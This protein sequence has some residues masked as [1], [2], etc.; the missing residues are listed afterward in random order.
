[1][2]TYQQLRTNLQVLLGEAQF[3]V[4]LHPQNQEYLHHEEYQEHSN[5]CPR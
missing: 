5:Y 3:I 2:T 4:P 1:M